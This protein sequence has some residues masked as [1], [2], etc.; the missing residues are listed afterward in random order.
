MEPWRVSLF[1]LI[2]RQWLID[3]SECLQ[4]IC[5]ALSIYTQTYEFSIT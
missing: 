1:T 2:L 3:T 5:Y 4:V